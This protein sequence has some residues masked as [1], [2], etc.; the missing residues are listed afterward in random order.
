MRWISFVIL[1]YLVLAMQLAAGGLLRFGT[2]SP[3]LVLPFVIFIAINA[4]REEA[5]AGTLIL[6][7]LHDLISQQPPGF[8]AFCYGLV[9]L[10]A[11]GTQ[12]AVYRDHPLTH[13][14]VTLAAGLLVG[15]ITV[16]NQWVLHHTQRMPEPLFWGA[17]SSA[18]YTA[19]LAPLLLFPLTRIKTLFAF[20]PA[21]LYA[22]EERRSR[23]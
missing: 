20:R 10:F 15:A 5:L 1:A 21:R 13:L 9:G 4:R 11:V 8:H 18:I 14:F 6:G 17:L 23:R 2:A 22:L 3:N 19:L 7:L 16:L 12:P